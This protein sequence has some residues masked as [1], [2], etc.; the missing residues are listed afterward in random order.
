M[1]W[2]SFGMHLASKREGWVE[3][4]G[5]VEDLM[6]TVLVAEDDEA[7]RA[8]LSSASMVIQD[9]MDAYVEDELQA[10]DAAIETTVDGIMASLFA[11]PA[12]A[13]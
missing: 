4:S 11:T 3:L 6:E 13:K 9:H 8:A 7:N 12:Q 2:L 5:L 10:Y 1:H